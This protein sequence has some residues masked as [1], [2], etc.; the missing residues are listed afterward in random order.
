MQKSDVMGKEECDGWGSFGVVIVIRFPHRLPTCLTLTS[1]QKVQAKERLHGPSGDGKR[2]R[3]EKERGEQQKTD[4]ETDRHRWL[5]RYH[6][7][8]SETAR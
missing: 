2:R 1:A 6:Y 7:H 4:R 5:S 3:E 8:H